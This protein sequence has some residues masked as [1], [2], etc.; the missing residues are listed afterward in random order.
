M[1]KIN[2]QINIIDSQAKKSL[3]FLDNKYVRNSIL[4]FLAIYIGIWSPRLPPSVHQLFQNNLF[5]MIVLSMVLFVST[6]DLGISLMMA[7]AFLISMLML[8]KYNLMDKR[9]EI[10]EKAVS[11]V[12]E[13]EEVD[14]N[15]GEDIDLNNGENLGF[16]NGVKNG[17]INGMT[18]SNCVDDMENERKK[19]M[20]ESYD[21]HKETVVGMPLHP[22]GNHNSGQGLVSVSGMEGHNIGSWVDN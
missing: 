2:K 6:K 1:D 19:V 17:G 3:S 22:D 21:N 8:R 20:N 11:N 18:G 4:T 7:L 10:Q 12:Q 14:T 9:Q 13:H 15:N 16:L 5:R